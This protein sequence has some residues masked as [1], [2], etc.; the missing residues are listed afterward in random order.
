MKKVA[1]LDS[2]LS[3]KTKKSGATVKQK[4]TA[5]FTT[6]PNII[7]WSVG[8]KMMK[9]FA[10]KKSN[11]QQVNFDIGVKFPKSL[12]V[13]LLKLKDLDHVCFYNAINKYNEHTLIIVGIDK[14]Q[15]PVFFKLKKPLTSSGNVAQLKTA[16]IPETETN[17]VGDM[18]QQCST[19]EPKYA[20]MR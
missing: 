1:R 17:G 16:A 10:N 11:L 7:P 5:K 18:G 8:K 6:H 3:T 15:K 9:D 13:E 2:A 12:F 19:V 20:N 4:G 14:Y